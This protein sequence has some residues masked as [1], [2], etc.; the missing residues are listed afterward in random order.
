MSSRSSKVRR[1][2]AVVVAAGLA[3]PLW[4]VPSAFAGTSR[5]PAAT[6]AYFYSAGIDKPA[7]SPT[8]PPNVTG[9][10]TDM[11]APEHLAVAV[12]VPNQVDKMSFLSF[13]L[14][15]VPFDATITSAVISVPLAPDGDGNMSQSPAAAKVRACAAGDEGFNGEDGASFA[16]APTVKCDVFMAPAKDS[17]D[18]KSYTFDVSKLAASWLTDANNG[19]ALTAADGATSSPFQVVF[20]PFAKASIALTFTVPS[21]KIDTTVV[22]PVLPGS[23]D[24]GGGGVASDPGSFDPGSVAAGSV[25]IAPA[26]E[27]GVAE[28]P[29]IDTAV[30]QP[31]VGAPAAAVATGAA[32]VAV[33]NVASGRP[34]E[35]LTPTTTAWLGALLFV[36]L[37]ALLSLIMGDPRVPVRATSQTRL[38]QALQERERDAGR[39]RPLRPLGA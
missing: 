3:V 4:A 33:T 25:D 7:E 34:S 18:K 10:R 36:G 21:T 27:F 19:L 6:G 31:E 37:L 9:D 13:D 1:T 8:Q 14:T 38:S 29:A 22:P 16:Q 5:E 15:S 28:S 11:V 12:R 17:A 26:P 23:T 39:R 20:Q 2:G 32:P 30:P 24:G 35:V